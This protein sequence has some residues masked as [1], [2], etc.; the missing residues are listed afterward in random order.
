MMIWLIHLHDYLTD[1]NCRENYETKKFFMP[2]IALFT[3]RR[4]FVEFRSYIRLY[5]NNINK[6]G[7][8]EW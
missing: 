1:V 5:I 4:S 8:E 7:G 2:N 3:S 6:D